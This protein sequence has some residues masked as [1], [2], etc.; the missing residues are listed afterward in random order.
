MA[1][2]SPLS[3]LPPEG[4]EEK[5]RYD[6]IQ[7]LRS[8]LKSA[9][10]A[11]QNQLFDPTL[12]A[13]AQGFLAPT[14]TGSFGESLGYAAGAVGKAQEG[15][16]QRAR[17]LA[18][19][20]LELAQQEFAEMQGARQNKE[21]SQ[22]LGRMF[23]GQQPAQPAQPAVDEFVEPEGG[24]MRVLRS[25]M[26]GGEQV[27]QPPQGA[28]SGAPAGVS[29]DESM[30]ALAT[31]ARTRP[32]QAKQIMDLLKFQSDRFKMEG[33]LVYDVRAP[34][35][36]RVVMD[37][38]QQGEQKPYEVV[39][40]GERKTVPM[41]QIEY[42]QYLEAERQGKGKDFFTQRLA[43]RA[44]ESWEGVPAGG[45]LQEISL[46]LPNMD[47][48]I[49]FRGT[50]RQAA[51]A[52]A[53]LERA[54]KSGD[55]APVMRFLQ[56][57][58]QMKGET[59]G[60]PTPGGAAEA[61][62]PA[63]AR[64]AEQ[65]GKPAARPQTRSDLASLPIAEQIKVMTDRIT[66]GDKPAQEEISTLLKVGSPNQTIASQTR[67]KEIANLARRH[68]EVFGL[69]PELGPGLVGALARAAQEGVRV[70]PYQLSGPANEFMA[71][72]NL[73][74]A[75]SDIARR[76]AQLLDE[77]FFARAN[78][79]KSVLGPQMSN[80]DALLMR[81][82]M[83]SPTDRAKLI[84][85]WAMNGILSNK[86]FEEMYRTYDGWAQRTGGRA[87][88]RNFWSTDGRDVMLKYADL[89]TQLQ[90]TFQPRSVR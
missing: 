51:Q 81:S 6:E 38:R 13:M 52:E 64:P 20:R 32:D 14:K 67:L 1:T 10:D 34:G 36:P 8:D 59:A 25:E 82:P 74:P 71:G 37:M 62:R 42:G 60:A 31:M 58:G 9:L 65:P 28:P 30:R 4:D 5:A 50:A 12:L 29:D 66:A 16:A 90:S 44:R 35:G 23:P 86:Q 57:V 19:M 53:L 26:P 79:Y 84:E 46:Y 80:A 24:G 33:N 63:E 89:F 83:A 88:P 47:Q 2:K 85:Y 48:Q 7:K 22:A 55:Y 75:Q 18:A 87:S 56:T 78:A 11:R 41:T 27:A 70:G 17:E 72:L 61:Q 39:I 3:T 45:A 77:E 49:T 73:T 54:T 69:I 40:D 76:M 15:E 68:P 21:F 43:G